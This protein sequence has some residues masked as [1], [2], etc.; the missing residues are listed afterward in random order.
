MIWVIYGL[1]KELVF[2]KV[3]QDVLE[4]HCVIIEWSY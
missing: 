4:K 1:N 3:T 2:I